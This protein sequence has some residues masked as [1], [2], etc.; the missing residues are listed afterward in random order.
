MM[1]DTPP[2]EGFYAGRHDLF[3]VFLLFKYL[4]NL[5]NPEVLL[6]QSSK[7]LDFEALAIRHAD[8]ISCFITNFTSKTQRIIL[9]DVHSGARL[10]RLNTDTVADFMHGHMEPAPE[11]VQW[12]KESRLELLPYELMRLDLPDNDELRL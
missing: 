7:P 6:T 11:I 4:L 12:R 10:Y 5:K 9:R 1:G 2:K 8:G 3:P